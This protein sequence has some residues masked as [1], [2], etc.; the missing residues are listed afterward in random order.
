MALTSTAINRNMQM[1]GVAD[2]DAFIAE[3]TDSI[4]YK[5]MREGATA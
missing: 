4:T 5:L 3:L 2:I 1:Y